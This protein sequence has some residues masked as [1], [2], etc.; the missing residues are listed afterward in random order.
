MCF[1]RGKL[2]VCIDLNGLV[3]I[4]RDD[5]TGKSRRQFMK[6]SATLGTVMAGAGFAGCL[7]EGGGGGGDTSITGTVAQLQNSY[8]QNWESGFVE[9]AEALGMSSQLKA[10]GG[11]VDK[12]QQDIDTAI[13]SGT[14]AVAGQTFTNATS[15]SLSKK[16]V[17]EEIP[18]VL[19]V[20]IADWWTP[21]DAGEEYVQ[22]FG[23]NFNTHGYEVGQLLFE[24]MGGSGNFVMIEGVR[25]TTA[26]TG[27]KQGV[28]RAVEEYSDIQQIGETLSANWLR[29]EGRDKMSTH[30]SQHGD[31]IDGLVALSDSMALGGITVI[32]ENNLDI[33]V[34]G[35]DGSKPAAEAIN[36][37]N[38]LATA[39]GVPAWEGGWS[40]VRCYDYI[41]GHTLSP[42]ERMMT[43][44]APVVVQ[45]SGE[46]QDQVEELEVLGASTY[47][48]N[49]F[50][51]PL[52]YD[53]EKM[54]KVESSDD[55]DPQLK[56]QPMDEDDLQEVL[57]W[58]P[59]EKPDDYSL[60]D[61]FSD[62]GT[63]E[64]TAQTY[65]EHYENNPLS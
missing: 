2:Y 29:S 33:P 39:S 64:E 6:K 46:W 32:Q 23:H 49:M 3:A 5:S 16:M 1:T 9:A 26:N 4:M 13:S 12:Q 24:A 59:A 45:D 60:P 61:V 8:W 18:F 56:L 62:Q 44:N 15:L 50:S 17:R 22:Y 53:W 38:M 19:A 55:W 37:G 27:R 11:D 30:V 7:S 25:G 47:L 58:D 28:R 48:D 20:M 31:D 57:G 51:D 63:L 54:S 14:D 41:N 10:N 52:P 36:Q 65:E 42:E 43:F 35:F 40:A 34:I 21:M